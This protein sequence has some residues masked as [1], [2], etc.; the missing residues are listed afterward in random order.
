M[1]VAAFA[2]VNANEAC[3]TSLLGVAQSMCASGTNVVLC[4]IMP[5]NHTA[6][7]C[8]CRSIASCCSPSY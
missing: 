1:L 2:A 7:V 6:V 5:S 8:W 4:V 3:V